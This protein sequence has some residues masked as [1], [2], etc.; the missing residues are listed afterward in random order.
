MNFNYILLKDAFHHQTIKVHNVTNEAYF[1]KPVKNAE[2]LNL[3]FY[4]T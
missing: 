4:L 2:I 3:L 1:Q